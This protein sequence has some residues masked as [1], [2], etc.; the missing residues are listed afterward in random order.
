[1]PFSEAIAVVAPPAFTI[2]APLLRFSIFVTSPVEKVAFTSV[3]PVIFKV[4]LLLIV[5]T[6]EKS[7]VAVKV[8][9]SADTLL[10]SALILSVPEPL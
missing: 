4:L 3:S 8:P 9:L 10:T 7:P 5:R 1:M 2:V 6:V